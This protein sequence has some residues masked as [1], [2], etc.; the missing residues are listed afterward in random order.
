MPTPDPAIAVQG[1]ILAT[2]AADPAVLALA[3]SPPRI[4]DDVPPR[5][6]YPYVTF[7]Q[8]IERD[9]SAGSDPGHEHTITLQVWSEANGRRQAAE[10]A[11]A[12]RH[13]LHDRPLTPSG[14][15][16]VNLRH[17]YTETRRDPDGA[18][19]RALVRFRAV[20]EPI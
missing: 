5:T 18:I 8:S 6:P 11:S 3:G 4:F 17:E 2:L 19:Y 13:A 20:T 14:H 16:L 10:I 12:I 15:H 9:W 7:G 1:A